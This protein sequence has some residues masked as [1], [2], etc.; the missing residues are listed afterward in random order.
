MVY[1]IVV[2]WQSPNNYL[3]SDLLTWPQL[4]LK[5]MYFALKCLFS[6]YSHTLN[7][8][9]YHFKYLNFLKFSFCYIKW[10]ETIPRPTSPLIINCVLYAF[11]S[12]YFNIGILNDCCLIITRT[13]TLLS[14]N[15]EN[16]VFWL[17]VVWNSPNT[18][19]VLNKYWK[20]SILLLT[21]IF[22][23]GFSKAPNIRYHFVLQVYAFGSHFF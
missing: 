2:G 3:P 9:Q 19:S 7:N 10:F 5:T 4:L 17:I 23:L 12:H 8:I 20:R 18:Y 21:F 1:W 11:D 13:L 14:I 16:Q 22:L 15:I 6:C